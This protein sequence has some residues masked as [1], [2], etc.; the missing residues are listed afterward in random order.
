MFCISKILSIKETQTTLQNK[1]TTVQSYQI[2][3]NIN[4]KENPGIEG[5]HLTV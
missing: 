3:S 1:E 4:T 5:A 2:M